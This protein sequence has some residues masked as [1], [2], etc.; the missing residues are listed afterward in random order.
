MNPQ[1]KRLHALIQYYEAVRCP[2]MAGYLRSILVATLATLA[3]TGCN[4]DGGAGNPALPDL[5][6]PTISQPITA[7]GG[8]APAPTP[9]AP[10][11]SVYKDWGTIQGGMP[12]D[13]TAIAPGT[14][15]RRLYFQCADGQVS[16]TQA[17]CIRQTAGGAY[18]GSEARR[19]VDHI[20]IMGTESEGTV[21]IDRTEVGWAQDT[22]EYA[23]DLHCAPNAGTYHYLADAQGMWFGVAGSEVLYVE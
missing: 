5:T 3:I 13:F 23:N 21:T 22:S 20:V 11:Y 9:A 1:A 2:V 10:T 15:V 19:C 8:T 16:V 6:Q 12:L 14:D 4:Q 18:Y 17:D 7:P